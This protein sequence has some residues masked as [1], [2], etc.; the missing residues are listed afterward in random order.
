M[1]K[2][3]NSS[4]NGIHAQRLKAIRP[5]VDF[6]FDLRKPLTPYQKAKVREYFNEIDALTA[7]PYY[8]YRPKSKDKLEKAQQFAQHEKR[9]PGLKVAFVPTADYLKPKIKFDKRG[10]ISVDTQYVHTTGLRLNKRK[11]LKNAKK[12]VEDVIRE[13]PDAQRFTILA[14][15]Y[16]INK[17]FSRTRI[18]EGVAFYVEKYGEDKGNHYFGN[19]LHG[20]SAHQFKEQADIAEYSKAR[21]KARNKHKAARRAERARAAREAR[22]HNLK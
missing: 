11:L 18:G 7:R 2:K 3:S 9:L 21:D 5:F 22:K 10:N 15:K 20:L 14:G 16:E 6:N 1:K 17:T 8:A 13:A 4:V 19:W 12:H